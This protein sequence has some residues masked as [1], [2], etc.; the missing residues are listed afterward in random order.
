MVKISKTV[1]V[2]NQSRSLMIAIPKIF[3]EALN[4][5]DESRISVTLDGD[6]LVLDVVKDDRE[7]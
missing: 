5:T 2:R 4:I 6:K 3:T 1:K 7:E